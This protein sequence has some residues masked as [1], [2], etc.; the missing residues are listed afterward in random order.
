MVQGPT[1]PA[2]SA[3]QAL[4]PEPYGSTSKLV[5]LLFDLPGLAL[6]DQLL[7]IGLLARSG[8]L[9]LLDDRGF[10]GRR[11]VFVDH[12]ERDRK[13]VGQLDQ[14]RCDALVLRVMDDDRRILAGD[15]L[16]AQAVDIERKTLGPAG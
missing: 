13:A 5:R 6:R 16:E 10:E 12:A 14:H 2:R 1:S 15:H 7:E 9:V 11:R 4:T 8:C 3:T